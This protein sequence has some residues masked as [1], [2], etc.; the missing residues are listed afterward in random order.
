[1]GLHNLALGRAIL[2]DRVLLQG[3]VR[4]GSRD[5][6]ARGRADGTERVV[7]YHADLA[8]LGQR[9]DLLGTGDAAAHADVWPDVLDGV[10]GQQHLE[11]VD[12]VEP[13]P[14]GNRDMDVL[15]HQ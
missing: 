3:E 11:L 10:A 5:L 1:R 13:L 2:A 12:R 6:D 14:G 4:H 9:R 15:R 8:R 7:R